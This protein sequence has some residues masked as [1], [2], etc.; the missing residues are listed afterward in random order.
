MN[1][2]NTKKNTYFNYKN[3]IGEAFL[4][5]LIV[6]IVGQI[7]AGVVMAPA[8]FVPSLMGVLSP[9]SFFAGFGASAVFIMVIKK[10]D[11]SELKNFFH[12]KIK[13]LHI[14][15]AILMYGASLPIAE[16][17]SMIFPT[18]NEGAFA[19]LINDILDV[20]INSIFG[21]K[22]TIGGIYEF[23]ESSFD[24]IFKH[25]IAAFI[26][27]CILAPILEELIFRGLILR[28]MLQNGINPWF[29]IF[30]TA[31]LFGAAHMNPWQF[32]GA[33]FL[34]II[35]GYVYWRTQSLVLCVFLHFLNNFIAYTVAQ[36]T[37]NIDETVFEPNYLIIIGALILMTAFGY[38]LYSQSHDTALEEVDDY[39]DI[40]GLGEE[41]FN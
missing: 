13:P 6:L 4:F 29:S 19:E 14:L 31:F 35:F 38:F 34:G 30:L 11:L 21:T 27:V 7:I 5:F 8:T 10:L 2:F 39:N 26:M 22:V 33:G 16:Y 20:L 32:M 1:D 3:T 17:L 36:Y 15:L 28:G 25:K 41:S 12:L 24:I 40:Q 23:M 9:L 18:T 37:E